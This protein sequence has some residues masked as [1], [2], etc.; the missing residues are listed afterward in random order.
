MPFFLQSSLK[1]LASLSS[2]PSLKMISFFFC[3]D[4]LA[5]VV[6]SCL[7]SVLFVK[8]YAGLSASS[9]A[10]LIAVSLVGVDISKVFEVK[11]K[12]EKRSFGFF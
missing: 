9:A 5:M 11:A 8:I 1:I 4:T 12:I 3:A 2:P 10:R 7:R 6:K